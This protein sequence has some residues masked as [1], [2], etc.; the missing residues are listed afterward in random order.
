[1]ISALERLRLEDLKFKASLD[2]QQRLR[3][4]LP[5]CPMQKKK[6]SVEEKIRYINSFTVTFFASFFTI[7]FT[8]SYELKSDGSLDD[9][10]DE[11][12][13]LV[14]TV[15]PLTTQ[16]PKSISVLPYKRGLNLKAASAALRSSR[17]SPA[18]MAF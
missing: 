9:L 11:S 17:V 18:P 2:T 14:I 7:S 10:G 5:H 4:K 8:H 1:M 3:L 15:S 16:N 6:L 12:R 13:V